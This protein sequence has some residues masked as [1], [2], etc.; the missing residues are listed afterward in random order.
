MKFRSA[1]QAVRFSYN[2]T[3]RAEY[4]KSDPL[5]V[6]GTSNDA[7]SPMDLHAQAAM[8]HAQV[9]RMKPEDR[10][11]VLTMY[12]RG[13][14]RLSAMR[15][16]ADV[17][18]PGLREVVPSR[19]DTAIVIAHWATKRPSIRTIAKVRGVSYRQVCAWRTAVLRAWLPLQTRASANL[20]NA[21]SG[22]G[23]SFEA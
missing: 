3:E 23:L 12:G 2:I 4:A 15:E 6:H 16:L 14:D 11:S 5:R 21:L 8:I 18:Y 10:A 1:E 7:L 19:N 22:A 9:G 20:F 13:E 17:L